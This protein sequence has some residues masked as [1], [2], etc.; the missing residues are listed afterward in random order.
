M[1]DFPARRGVWVALSDLYLDNEPSSFYENCACSLAASPYALSELR[2]ILLAE[3]HPALYVNLLGVAGI[4]SGFDE[5]WLVQRILRQ[6]TLP[7]WRRARG[8]LMH[9][10]ARSLWRELE[11]RIVDY[12]CGRRYFLPLPI[13]ESA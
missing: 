2:E 10:C 13:A 9:H 4:W 6:Q 7:R 11:P 12:R 5:D 1:K 3:V 8:W